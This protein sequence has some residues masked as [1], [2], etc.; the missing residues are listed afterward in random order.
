M[1]QDRNAMESP[2]LYQRL[3]TFR[4]IQSRRNSAISMSRHDKKSGGKRW[5]ASQASRANQQP[6]ET[7]KPPR[8]L[9]HDSQHFHGAAG[10][11]VNNQASP[12]AFLVNPRHIVSGSFTVPLATR[13][14]QYRSTFRFGS[15]W[16]NVRNVFCGGV[17][18]YRAHC[19]VGNRMTIC[20]PATRSCKARCHRRMHP[21]ERCRKI[22]VRMRP[23][24]VRNGNR[25][26]LQIQDRVGLSL[27]PPLG[28][29]WKAAPAG[30][31]RRGTKVA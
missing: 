15:R 21:R 4:I 5:M 27:A 16:R 29:V 14:T 17:R 19:E 13:P 28:L 8:D 2:N 10:R 11:I 18:K 6:I 31:R 1:T 26:D 7:R 25:D 23:I 20:F 30:L 22:T 9:S 12:L 3:R 24:F